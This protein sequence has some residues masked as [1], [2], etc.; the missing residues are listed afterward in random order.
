MLPVERPVAMHP[1][2]LQRIFGEA[3]PSGSFLGGEKRLV[4]HVFLVLFRHRWLRATAHAIKRKRRPA[5]SRRRK[6]GSG[7]TGR[8]R[9]RHPRTAK[10]A[11]K[12]GAATLR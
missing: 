5:W 9:E 1:H 12:G 4:R 8:G 7:E 3:E 11:R 10:R 2:F 6:R